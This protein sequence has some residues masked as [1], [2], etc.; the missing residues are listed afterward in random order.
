MKSL[1]LIM[2]ALFTALVVYTI[3]RG[4]QILR[5]FHV[6]RNV[7]LVATIVLFVSLIVGTI[8]GSFMSIPLPRV[9]A[10]IG[11]TALIFFIYLFM[12]FFIADIIRV[13]NHF[14]H[15]A[16][17]GMWKFRQWAFIGALAIIAVIMIIGS[18]KFNHP[19]IVN[20]N[21]TANNCTLQNKEIKIVAASD[22]HLGNSITKKKLQKYVKSINDQQ[23]DLVLL[24]GDVCDNRLEP[25]IEQQMNEDLRMIN[26]PLGVYAVL[27][28]HEYIGRN[29]LGAI[30][31]LESGNVKILRDSAVLINDEF[32]IIGRDDR[33]NKNREKIGDLVHN[34][35]SDKPFILLDHQPFHLNEAE[36][37]GIDIQLSG[38][39]HDGQFFPINLIVKSMYE[40]AHG[41]STRGNTHYYISSGLGLWG[42]QYRIGTQS[43]LIVINLKY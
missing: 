1:F 34:L 12:A 18:Y 43:E 4:C 19:K 35:N 26:A 31:Y 5:D 32:Y 7:Y 23:P 30:E 38:H 10:F 27:G 24:V 33:T 36:E 40:N 6:L 41:Y 16:P 2:P 39:T 3:I 29:V 11:N 20:L 25:I 9:T 22:I 42:P 21:I 37:N 28:N 14:F 15:F 17:E 13:V 8:M